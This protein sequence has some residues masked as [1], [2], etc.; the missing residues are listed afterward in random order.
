M[1][2]DII[3]TA[4]TIVFIIFV[5]FIILIKILRQFTRILMII[6]ILP[7]LFVVSHHLSRFQITEG[8]IFPKWLLFYKI[9]K[10]F[11]CD[12]RKS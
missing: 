6:I 3:Q 4:A 7:H 10:V 9:P 1:N 2:R 11:G 12:N 5:A 8:K